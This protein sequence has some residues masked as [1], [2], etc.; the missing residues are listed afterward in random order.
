MQLLSLAASSM[1]METL[2]VPRMP[3][4][5][6]IPRPRFEHLESALAETGE[7]NLPLSDVAFA[8]TFTT[9]TVKSGW[10]AVQDGLYSMGV[11]KHLG[12]EFPPEITSLDP[13]LDPDHPT[14]EGAS[15]PQVLFMEDFEPVL[16][17][18]VD[19]AFGATEGTWSTR[20]S[21]A[22]SPTWTTC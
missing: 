12:E 9:Q 3:S 17:T 2:L 6:I 22:H 16:K 1:R 14:F 8:F 15:N 13:I 18:I 4:F 5:I 11:Q 19:A 10:K 21:R 7:V 20:C